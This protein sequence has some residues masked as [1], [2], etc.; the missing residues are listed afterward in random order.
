ML[1][2]GAGAA[3]LAAV[4]ATWSARRVVATDGSREVL[5]LLA[6]N[7]A[8][9]SSAFFAERVRLRHL[10]WGDAR[11]IAELRVSACVPPTCGVPHPRSAHVLLHGPACDD[12]WPS[13]WCCTICCDQVSGLGYS[14]RS[15]LGWWIP[16]RIFV[17]RRM[18]IQVASTLSWARTW[19]MPPNTCLPFLPPPPHCWHRILPLPR[20]LALCQVSYRRAG[21]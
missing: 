13:V 12:I 19:C 7:L 21:R 9:N 10:A 1:E 4:A 14:C 5:Q 16:M 18:S 8:A 2:V 20:Q 15:V 3:G 6:G 17:W 11:H